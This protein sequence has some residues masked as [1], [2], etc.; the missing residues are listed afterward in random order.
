ML[1]ETPAGNVVAIDGGPVDWLAKD[2][3]R[4][5]A[6][7]KKAEG[8][9]GNYASAPFCP[10]CGSTKGDERHDEDCPAFTPDGAV[11]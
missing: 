8:A 6:L 1:I 5:R 9:L 3:A 10:W 7:V 2:N 11:K 4:L